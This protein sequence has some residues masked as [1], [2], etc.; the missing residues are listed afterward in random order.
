MSFEFFKTAVPIQTYGCRGTAQIHNHR[1]S[2]F[3][4]IEIER[5]LVEHGASVEVQDER[6]MNGAGLHGMLRL[7]RD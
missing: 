3:G 7:S 1:T 6:G 2:Q 4:W 5:V